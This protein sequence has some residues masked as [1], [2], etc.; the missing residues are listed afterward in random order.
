VRAQSYGERRPPGD[1][2][3][4]SSPS[5]Q[6]FKHLLPRV[7]AAHGVIVPNKV[8]WKSDH[9]PTRAVDGARFRNCRSSSRSPSGTAST[10]AS[11][12]QHYGS[13]KDTTLRWLPI[14]AALY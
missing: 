4:L 13:T 10:T 2:N 1:A 5:G 12:A 6:S 8:G 7:H 9:P 11:V 14:L 3:G